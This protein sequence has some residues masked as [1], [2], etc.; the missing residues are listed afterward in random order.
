[1]SYGDSQ[2]V[3]SSAL[4]GITLNDM[5][6]FSKSSLL[7]GEADARMIFSMFIPLF[8]YILFQYNSTLKRAQLIFRQNDETQKS[9]FSFL[10]KSITIDAIISDAMPSGK[11]HMERR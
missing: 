5:P 8:S 1:M 6:A 11:E 10:P 4:L 9:P 2:V 7:R 3:F